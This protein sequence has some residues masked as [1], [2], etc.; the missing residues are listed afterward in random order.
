MNKP[1][2]YNIRC[3]RCH[4]QEDLIINSRRIIKD[5]TERISFMCRKCVTDRLKKYRDTPN[6]KLKTF[7]AI[8]KSME[9]H[10]DKMKARFKLNYN[11]RIGNIIKPSICPVCLKKKKIEGHHE[12]YTKP[13]DV[14][15]MCKQCHFDY[16]RIICYYINNETF[17]K[18]K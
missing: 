14:K 11:I 6:G 16:H 3:Q 1:K 12:D 2:K 18:R 13:L 9:K 8:Y 4:T 15:W 10:K 5:G 17:R 7:K